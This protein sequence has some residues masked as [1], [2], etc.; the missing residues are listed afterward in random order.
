MKKLLLVEDDPILNRN[1]K[2][3]LTAEGME[4]DV[5]FDGLLASKML[6]KQAY[7]CVV[8]DINLPSQ[9]GYAVC[10]DFRQ[11]NTT[12]PVLMLTAFGEL[13]DKIQGYDQGADDYLTKPFYMRELILRINALIKRGMFRTA[14][15]GSDNS[16]V[17]GD[18]VVDLVNKT[19]LRQGKEV[20]LTPREYQILLRL[21]RSKGELV[22]KKDLVQEIWGTSL[23]VNTNTIEVY[24]NF[25]RKKIDK[26]FN[27]HSIRTK[28][29]FGYYFQTDEH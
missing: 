25:L 1:I 18:I 5:V 19:V 10:H 3:A 20:L 7:D 8:L 13:E 24:I 2:E 22:A 16:I 9:N 4:V 29:G 6:A 12:T 17:A 26:P 23:D 14:E 28:V 11:Y 15:N 21:L 27:K